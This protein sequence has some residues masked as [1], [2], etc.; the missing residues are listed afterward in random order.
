MKPSVL[1][2]ISRPGC[3]ASAA[4]LA[5]ALAACGQDP[6]PKPA[7]KV[8]ELAIQPAP[9]APAMKA[10]AQKS[11]ADIQ[12]A[13]DKELAA[14]VKSTLLAE[15]GVNAHTIDVGAKQGAVTLFG[16][17]ETR[18]RRALAEKVAGRVSGVKSVENKLVIVA[19][20]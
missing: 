2:S 3:V 1:N 6:A 17:A 10:P 13:A 11:P 14:R 12:A 16:T 19:G 9:P 20:S 4:L 15:K 5:L 18:E 7:P 8:V